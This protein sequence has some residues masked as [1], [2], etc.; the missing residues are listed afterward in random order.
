MTQAVAALGT[1]L[2]KETPAGS[3]TY[4][5][6]AEVKK[7]KGPTESLDSIEVTNQDSAGT[8]EYIQGLH[9]GGEVTFT[10][11]YNVG[12]EPLRTFGPPVAWRIVLPLVSGVSLGYLSFMA[13][14][15]KFDRDF[16]ETKELS[17]DVTLKVSG[18]VTFTAGGGG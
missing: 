1:K 9:D 7:L 3:G 18:L 6:V 8:K 15:T 17:V 10:V 16:D 5:T 12:H 2:K 13:N 11:N 4:V 14:V